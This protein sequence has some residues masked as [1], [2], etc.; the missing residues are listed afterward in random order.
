MLM[1][2]RYYLKLSLLG[3]KTQFSPIWLC[4]V[5][6]AASQQPFSPFPYRSCSDVLTI[7]TR[8]H[9]NPL[10]TKQKSADEMTASDS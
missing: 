3:C 5:N 7:N 9:V 8:V 1:Y 6:L 4:T 10:K 2:S